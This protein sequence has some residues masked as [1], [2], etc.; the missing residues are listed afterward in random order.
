MKSHQIIAL[1]LLSVLVF[2]ALE[3][4][5]ATKSAYA[6]DDDRW[7][8]GKNAPADTYYIY[9][10]Q[11]AAVKDGAPF[12]MAL[13]LQEQ[14]SSGDW[15]APVY[16]VENTGHVITGTFKLGENLAVLS[17]SSDIPEEMEPYVGGY[18]DTL[19]WLEAFTNKAEPES[20]NAVTWGKIACIGCGTLDPKGSEQVT[21]AGNTYDTTVLV[22]HRGQTDSKIWVAKELPYPVKAKT[23]ADVTAGLPPIQYVFDLVETGAGQLPTPEETSVIPDSPLTLT[24]GRGTYA[25][26][27]SW[28]PNEIMPGAETDFNIQFENSRGVPMERTNY[29]FVVKS[30]ATG[31]VIQEFTNQNTGE[32]NTGDVK[33]M[34]DQ[35]GPVTVTVTINSVAGATTDPFIE[36][37]DFNIVVV[38]E[39]PTII[40]MLALAAALASMVMIGRARGSILGG[41][42]RGI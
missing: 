35:G 12:T 30:A 17:G 2:S 16:V 42:R 10:I 33:V 28:S 11:D 22:N 20:L 37:A 6:Q 7:Y 23:Y 15:T 9:K 32:G 8:I 41:G 25:M 14:D 27:L 39:F 36:S 31:D 3:V 13:Y 34:F 18:Q 5:I 21:A 4:S 40:A 24:T 38:P 19:T 1:S 26:T 29:D